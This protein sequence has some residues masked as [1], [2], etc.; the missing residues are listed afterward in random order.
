[1]RMLGYILPDRFS[2]ISMARLARTNR[3]RIHQFRH[4][5]H[6]HLIQLGRIAF[7]KSTGAW[8]GAL[9]AIPSASS[10]AY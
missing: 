9:P 6:L 1:M 7:T 8:S 4:Q 5:R 10:S 3:Y 2:N